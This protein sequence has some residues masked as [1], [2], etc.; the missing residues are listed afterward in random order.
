MYWFVIQQKRY[1]LVIGYVP[2]AYGLYKLILDLFLC[3]SM[4]NVQDSVEEDEGKVEDGK[5]SCDVSDK[6][7]TVF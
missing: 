6:E 3:C 2:F 1:I 7:A 5:G 4:D